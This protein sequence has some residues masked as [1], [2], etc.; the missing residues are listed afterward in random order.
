MCRKPSAARRS[1][2][3]VQQN[4]Q[5][6]TTLNIE[7]RV[8]YTCVLDVQLRCAAN[9]SAAIGSVFEVQQNMMPA[10]IDA[11]NHAF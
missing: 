4:M 8:D 6:I 7:F 2:L 1:V 3:D 9:A 10:T 5:S 11:A